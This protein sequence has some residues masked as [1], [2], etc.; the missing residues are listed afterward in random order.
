MPLLR[1]VLLLAVLVSAS[2]AHAASLPAG[3]APGALWLSQSAPVAGTS[4]R[5]YAVTYNA[6]SAAIE[7]SVSFTVDGEPVGSSPFSLEPGESE[8]ESVTWVPDEGS[9]QIAATIS[10]VIDKK[11][12]ESA[13][14]ANT[15]AAAVSITVSPEPP[16]PPVAEALDSA[17]T[18]AA[19]STPAVSGVIA[20]TTGATESIRK[21]GENYLA[22]LAGEIPANV[23][24]ST[25]NKA[26]SVLGAATESP[27]EQTASTTPA[28]GYMQSIAKAL[29]P[30]FRYPALFYPLFLFILLFILWL[31]GK[32]LRNPKRRR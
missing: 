6:G 14:V 32:R 26:G 1:Y 23:T 30:I 31:I 11:S 18:I 12:K 5:L 4:V 27:E 13:T 9:H 7:G 21:A 29:L 2:S 24:A 16:K 8:I 20:A 15:A 10:S 22:T 19:S 25:T 17:Q 28:S 3:F